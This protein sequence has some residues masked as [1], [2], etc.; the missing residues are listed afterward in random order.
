MTCPRCH[1]PECRRV[2]ANERLRAWLVSRENDRRTDVDRDAE[3]LA[4]E[5]YRLCRE[6]VD[7]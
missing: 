3:K 6:L 7:A 1:C 5:V 2:K 4:N